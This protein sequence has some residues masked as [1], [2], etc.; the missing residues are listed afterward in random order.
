[1]ALE[2]V[3]KITTDS[4]D[5]AKD[6]QKLQNVLK[7]VFGQPFEFK[8]I[9]SGKDGVDRITFALNGAYYQAE[10]FSARM[11]EVNR[12][13]AKKYPTMGTV[14]G[15]IG[16]TGKTIPAIT[17]NPNQ[18]PYPIGPPNYNQYSHKI[19]PQRNPN[20]YSYP[21]G[22]QKFDPNQYPYPIGPTKFDPNQYPYPIGPQKFNPNQ[23]SYP[24]G[25]IKFDPN[26]Y[27]TPIG[28]PNYNQYK[29]P[30]GPQQGPNRME[31]FNNKM[32]PAIKG[33]FM[34]QM[35]SL[36][37]AFSF[38]SIQNSL[39]GLF[40][41]LED[42]GT[43]IST[44]SIGSV[45]SQMA[46]GKGTDIAATMGV[47][48]E[49]QTQ[50]WAG[51]TA[52]VSQIMAIFNS[53]A[54]KVLSPDMVAAILTII[55]ALAVQLAKPE[56]TKAIQELVYAI[57]DVMAAVIPLLPLLADF[58]V[59]LG[60]SG[61]LKVFVAL[62]IA[63][64]VLLPTLAFVE[65]AMS[66]IAVISPILYGAVALVGGSFAVLAGVF[67]GIILIVDFL[68]HLFV[69]LQN[70]MDPLRAILSALG[71]TAEDVWNIISGVVKAVTGLFGLNIGSSETGA[72]RYAETKT[73][74]INNNFNKNVGN[75]DVKSAQRIADQMN[76]TQLG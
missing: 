19:G 24:I 58:V 37:V 14:T 59:F 13:V 64:E 22:P 10:Q 73:V 39:I 62:I 63:A 28:P 12:K 52:I 41:G 23:Y 51:F 67:V 8:N 47:T 53:L 65:F 3:I 72:G 33:I 49:M 35:A 56:V 16:R 61:L 31:Q 26:Q 17:P 70:G 57:L 42:L 44:G 9:K 75:A 1:M 20:Q 15:S 60:E 46:G 2:E 68:W 50:A 25:P 76:A 69:N 48:P 43:L 54:V 32:K 29:N 36:G 21:I 66:A 5:S 6:I 27:K 4:S 7:N 34:L 38:M 30:I 71:Q 11:D 55:D 18:Y 74:T 45:F 40:G